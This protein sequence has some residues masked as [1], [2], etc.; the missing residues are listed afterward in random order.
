[1]QISMLNLSAV[2]P[3]CPGG[4]FVAC[5]IAQ[6]LWDGYKRISY[7]KTV[8]ISK[9][10]LMDREHKSLYKLKANVAKSPSLADYC[11][12]LN[13]GGWRTLRGFWTSEKEQATHILFS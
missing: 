1:M 11:L 10:I 8:F 2:F 9:Q 6:R 13:I 7:H 4:A 5:H 3:A 12:N